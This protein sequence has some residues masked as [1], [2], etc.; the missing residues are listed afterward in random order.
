[1]RWGSFRFGGPGG[2]GAPDI[3]R[4]MLDMMASQFGDMDG[5]EDEPDD[6]RPPT[7]K[8]KRK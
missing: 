6:E 5:F 2:R 7:P 3:F 1:M 4:E 8:R